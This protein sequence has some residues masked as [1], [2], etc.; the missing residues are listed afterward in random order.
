MAA[1]SCGEHIP[2]LVIILNSFLPSPPSGMVMKSFWIGVSTPP[3]A[4]AL[5]RN[6][7]ASYSVASALVMR[8]TPP[9]ELQ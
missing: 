1:T 4:T 9:L 3:G 5:T 7:V 2:F 8:I 6:G